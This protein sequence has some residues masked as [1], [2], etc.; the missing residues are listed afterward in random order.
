MKVLV[1]QPRSDS[2]LVAGSRASTRLAQRLADRRFNGVG[3]FLTLTY[4]RKAYSSALE[5]YRAQRDERHVRRF[6]SRLEDATGMD[7]TGR[8]TR[9]LEFQA[10]GWVHWHLILD[11]EDRIPQSLITEVWGHGHTWVNAASW[12]RIKYFAKYLAKSV[13]DLP[14]WLLAERTRSV[15]VVATSPG[16]WGASD[17]HPADAKPAARSWAVFVPIAEM[18]KQRVIVKTPE[19]QRTFRNVNVFGALETL[20]NQGGGMVLGTEHEYLLLAITRN[21]LEDSLQ[22]IDAAGGRQAAR[23]RGSLDNGGKSAT[24]PIFRDSR[25]NDFQP[26]DDVPDWVVPA[27]RGLGTLEDV[28]R[29][30][31]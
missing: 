20:C 15:K 30:G 11:A 24:T 28:T 19:Y 1:K 17:D 8:W 7:L 2:L 18:N 27:M 29:V 25:F 23:R 13:D 6:I 31:N 14:E 5:L 3:L 10:G 12:A 21:G 26:P 4:D 9:K 22:A 16:F